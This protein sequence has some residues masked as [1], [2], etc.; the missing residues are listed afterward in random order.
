M[1]RHGELNDADGGTVLDF[2]LDSGN[3]IIAHPAAKIAASVLYDHIN[4]GLFT[5]DV[6]DPADLVTRA[7]SS[8]LRKRAM[9]EIDPLVRAERA[10]NYP[11][12]ADL[13]RII[14]AD[15]RLVIVDPTLRDR[16]VAR[17]RVDFVSLVRG[18]VQIWAKKLDAL[19]VMP[20]PGRQDV[21]WW[22]H[23]YDPEF[24]GYMAGALRIQDFITTGV[25][26]Y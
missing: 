4:A 9:S 6:V 19:G 13:G 22:P 18:S 8:E 20:V 15:T 5:A 2:S 25:E 14:T 7:M 1:N 24:L 17:E 10:R 11:E 26:I 3:G 12:V 21:F 16:I 23:E